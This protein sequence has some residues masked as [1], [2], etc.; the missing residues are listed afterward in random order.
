MTKTDPKKYGF[1]CH[2]QEDRSIYIRNQALPI[3]ARCTGVLL[4]IFTLP[5]FHMGILNH[6][7]YIM[8]ILAAPATLDATTQYMQWRVS[9]NLLRIITGFLLGSALAVLVVI[10]GSMIINNLQL[11]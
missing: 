10:S 3:C 7:I 2:K 5:L 11:L 8:L 9:N 6:S 1:L 4:G